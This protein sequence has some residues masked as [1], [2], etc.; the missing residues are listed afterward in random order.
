LS[1]TVSNLSKAYGAK[2]A[3]RDLSFSM[4]EPGVFG[5]LGTNGAGKTTSIRMMLG[6]I[7]ADEGS[8]LWNGIPISRETTPFGYMPEERGLYAKVSV[9]EQLVYFAMLKGMSK[10]EAESS[11]RT[12]LD[13]LG[14]AEYRN[15]P[16]ESLSKGNQQKIQL[17]ATLT[18]KPRLLVLDEPFSGLDPLNTEI[19]RELI[20][21]LAA[22]GMYIIMSSHQMATVEEFCGDITILHRGRQVLSGSLSA[23]KAGYGH[24]RLLLACREDVA[25]IAAACGLRAAGG[26]N[27]YRIT[28]DEM[29][30]RFLAALAA[31][32]ILPA[33]FEITEPSLH[34]IFLS[35]IAGEDEV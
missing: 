35:A 11:V 12:W 21:E 9:A 17:I 1:L 32:N 8:A 26:A 22:E 18:P 2:P 16:A 13:R 24:T 3:V 25:A 28:G 14:M 7:R 15:A 5:L 33:R 29:A 20:S 27:E 30:G 23:I 10:A 4:P 6:I 34:E 31:A 19:L